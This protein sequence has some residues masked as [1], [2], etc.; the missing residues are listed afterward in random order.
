MKILCSTVKWSGE[1]HRELKLLI[2][3]CMDSDHEWRV[4]VCVDAMRGACGA[5]R[6]CEEAWAGKQI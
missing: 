1:V 3:K 4:G 2:Y 6:I 5:L